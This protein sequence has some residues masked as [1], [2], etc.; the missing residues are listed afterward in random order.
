MKIDA[1]AV[2]SADGCIANP[3]HPTQDWASKADFAHFTDVKSGYKLLIMGLATYR[4]SPTYLMEPN[5]LPENTL[6]VILTSDPSSSKNKPI[7][8]KREFVNLTAQQVVAKYSK[9]YDSALLLGGS[10]VYTSFIE[11]GLIDEFYITTEDSVTL[12]QENNATPL[13]LDGKSLADFPHVILY[14]EHPEPTTT[15]TKIKFNT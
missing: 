8:G 10:V 4:N 9:S 13:L 14:N 1:I 11:A 7:P 3:D 5:A 12:N 2:V 6:R 15:I